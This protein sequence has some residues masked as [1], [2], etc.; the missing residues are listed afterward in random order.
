MPLRLY[1]DESVARPVTVAL[2]GQDVDVLSV[3]ADGLTGFPDEEVLERATELGRVI[4]TQDDDFLLHGAERQRSG[5]RFPGIVYAHQTRVTIGQCI[6]D[7]L[8]MAQAM[9][10]DEMVNRIEYLPLR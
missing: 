2:R 4:F 3:Q 6:E 10:P 8:L 1:M 5:Q 7:L 9:E